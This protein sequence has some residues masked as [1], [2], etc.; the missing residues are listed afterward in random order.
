MKFIQ[1]FDKYYLE[2][3]DQE[4]KIDT[5]RPERKEKKPIKRCIGKCDRKFFMKDGEPVIY[6]PSCDRILN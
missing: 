3:K 1:L 4:P 5:S 6:C 2:S